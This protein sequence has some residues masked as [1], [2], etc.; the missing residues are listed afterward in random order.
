MGLEIGFPK[1]TTLNIKGDKKR[2]RWLVD[3]KTTYKNVSKTGRTEP[4][5]QALLQQANL[6]EEDLL[7]ETQMLYF[8][9]EQD[10]VLLIELDKNL[11][12]FFKE[13]QR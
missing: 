13:G 9:P 4:D 7:P 3:F 6:R 1:C 10:N 11:H 2:K 5:V 12:N 8:S